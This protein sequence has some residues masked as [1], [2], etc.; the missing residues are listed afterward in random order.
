MAAE[1]GLD[2]TSEDLTA[3][4]RI[5]QAALAHF[6]EYGFERTTIRGIAA[7]AGVSLGLVRHHFG[8]K[9]ALRDAIDAH[10]LQE[11]RRLSAEVMANGE[12]GDLGPSALSA[13]VMRPYRRYLLRALMDGSP[14]IATV[15]DQMVGPTEGWIALADEKRPDPPFADRRT[16]A[17]VFTAMVLGVPLLH[18]HLSRVLGVDTLSPEGD[19]QVSLALLDLYSHALVSPELA[20]TA[21]AG[22][23]DPPSGHSA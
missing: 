12:R 17:A 19:R 18:E 22:L 21:R 6:A 4:A 14:T 5:R 1:P 16:R 7:A 10:V 2:P 11:I 23:D 8:S 9:Q 13:Q 3:R 20:A 15:F